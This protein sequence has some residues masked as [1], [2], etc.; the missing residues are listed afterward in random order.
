MKHILVC[1]K[2]V[3]STAQ[4]QV[5]GHFR[6]QR[7]GTNLQWNIADEAALEKALQIKDMEGGSVTLLTMGPQKMRESLRPLLARGADR[8]ILVTD[9]KLAGA[10]TRATALAIATAVKKVGYFDLILC[11]RRAIDGETGQ[12][13]GQL[14]AAL[15]I[16]CVTNVEQLQPEGNLMKLHR[17]L[18]DGICILKTKMPLVASVCE[19]SSP[20]RLPKIIELRR[21]RMKEILCLSAKDLELQ[22][23]DMGLTGS[24]T[25]VVAMEGRFPGLRKGPKTDNVTVGVKQLLSLCKEVT[26]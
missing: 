22:P 13:P 3:P 4:V 20:L 10:D 26:Q 21:A 16:P 1:L 8:A 9:P 23:Q 18:E 19:Y 17:R 24:L 15:G 7:E 2:A 11:G 25:R 14:A 5:D 12:V 6:L